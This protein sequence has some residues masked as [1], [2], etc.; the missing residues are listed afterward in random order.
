MLPLPARPGRSSCSPRCTWLGD[1]CDQAPRAAPLLHP[2][3]LPLCCLPI[4]GGAFEPFLQQMEQRLQQ[5]MQQGIQQGMQ[6]VRQEVQQVR[7]E[8]Q[9]LKEMTVTNYNVTARLHNRTVQQ[10]GPLLPLRTER[11][12]AAAAAAPAAAP[13]LGDLPGPGLF[14][15]SWAAF[16]D[17]VSRFWGAECM[18]QVVEAGLRAPA[19][20]SCLNCLNPMRASLLSAVRPEPSIDTRN[21]PLCPLQWTHVQVTDLAVFYQEDFGQHNMPRKPLPCFHALCWGRVFVLVSAATQ[22]VGMTSK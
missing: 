3:L 12:P 16:H 13:Q 10:A 17:D 8:V 18:L 7:Q 9:T 22:H 15:P 20:L 11:Q 21:V 2:G 5:G 6:Q 19:A 14:P 4:A 1:G